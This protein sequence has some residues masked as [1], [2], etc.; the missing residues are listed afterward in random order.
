MRIQL[1]GNIEFPYEVEQCQKRGANG[2]GLYRTEFLFLARDE[3]PTEEEQTTAYSAVAEAMREL[4]VVMRTIDLGAD[5]LPSVPFPED[6][7][8]PFLGL[9]SIRLALRNVPMFR[10]DPAAPV[11]GLHRCHTAVRAASP[12]L[13]GS[14]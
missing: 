9:R 5:K 1:L 14:V 3:E 11:R 4:P 12:F 10:A 2:I 8:N 6:E 13:D 7:G